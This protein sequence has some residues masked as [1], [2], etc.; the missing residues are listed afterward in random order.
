MR[1]QKEREKQQACAREK[2]KEEDAGED[3]S[4]MKENH[5]ESRRDRHRG[6]RNIIRADFNGSNWL[7]RTKMNTDSCPAQQ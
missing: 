5:P 7:K 2:Q 3:V 4:R 6:T 1:E